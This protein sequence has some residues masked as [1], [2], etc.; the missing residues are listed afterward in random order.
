[1]KIETFHERQGF[2]TWTIGIR[3]TVDGKDYEA[4][5]WNVLSR[6]G[7]VRATTWRV[8]LHTLLDKMYADNGLEIVARPKK[9]ASP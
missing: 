9:E 4:R 8:L 7:E 3:A 2:D 5:N 1:M 6:P